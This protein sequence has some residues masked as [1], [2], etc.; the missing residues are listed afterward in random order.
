VIRPPFYCDYG[1]NIS[2]S[3]GVFLNA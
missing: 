2:L 3:P 1:C